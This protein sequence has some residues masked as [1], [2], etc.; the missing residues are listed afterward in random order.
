MESRATSLVA[1]QDSRRTTLKKI[2]ALFFL[3]LLLLTGRSAVAETFLYESIIVGTQTVSSTAITT[4]DNAAYPNI[5][6]F[7]TVETGN[8]RFRTDGAAPTAA[9][10]HLLYLGDVLIIEGLTDIRNFKA[11]STTSGTSTL[12]ISYKRK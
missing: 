8:I 12:R 1:L 11:I 9:E 2:T 4:I 10:G 6:G 7:Y 5:V 3:V